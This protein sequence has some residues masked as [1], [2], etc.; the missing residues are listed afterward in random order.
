MQSEEYNYFL[1]SA[2][3]VIDNSAGPNSFCLKNV[4]DPF[5]DAQSSALR[6][7]SSLKNAVN[8][9]DEQLIAF[10]SRFIN[11]H[12][13]VFWASDYNDVF[14][15]LKIILKK[16]KVKSAR[17]PNVQSSY[18]FKEL[19]IKYFLADQRIDLS[20]DGDLQFFFADRM[21]V[22]SGSLLLLNQSNSAFDKISNHRVNIF[23]TT[24][25]R[26]LTS[27][28]Y[29]EIYRQLVDYKNTRPGQDYLI[30]RG[31]TQCSNYLF[32]VDNGRSELLASLSQR[33]ALTCLRC[34]RCNDVCPVFQTIGDEPYNNV[35][36]GP[37]GNVVLPFLEGSDNYGHVSYLCTLCGRCEEVCPIHLPIRDMIVNSRHL[38]Y[39][40]GVLS[41]ENKKNIDKLG[42]F[43]SSRSK[44]DRKKNRK[45][46]MLCKML[47]AEWK[48]SRMVPM[49]DESTSHRIIVS[50]QDIKGEK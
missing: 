10:E 12:N 48:E 44:M 1:D 25:N 50:Q 43:L 21:L 27:T 7:Y 15:S 40:Q 19:G 28:S 3:K 30:T 34:D 5:V 13:S 31:S 45:H 20:E 9:L 14:E 46:R 8:T 17:L 38:M 11:K 16:H 18:I 49:F 47:S 24:V 41:K 23:I 6:L 39:E 36:Y 33:D 4:D 42:R 22:D 32:V 35:F 2:S 26:V 29:V 37:I